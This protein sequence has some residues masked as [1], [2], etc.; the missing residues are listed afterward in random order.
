MVINYRRP[1]KETVLQ[2][3]YLTV[4]RLKQGHTQRAYARTRSGVSA[5]YNEPGAVCWCL[6]GAIYRAMYDLGLESTYGVFPAVENAIMASR[7]LS[8]F[9][10]FSLIAFN[11]AHSQEEVINLVHRAIE[12]LKKEGQA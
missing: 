7:G 11:D 1:S 12:H 3:L 2:V 10:K 4:E 8:K 6:T 5:R 9:S